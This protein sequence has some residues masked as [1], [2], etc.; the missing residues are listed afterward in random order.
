MVNVDLPWEP[1]Y[2]QS[3]GVAEVDSSSLFYYY[4]LASAIVFTLVVHTFE[5]Y[6]DARQ[7]SSYKETQFP[8]E[9]ETTVLAIDADRARENIINKDTNTNDK[10]PDA[11]GDETEENSA[12]GKDGKA[13]T[14]TDTHKP[15]LPQLKEKFKSAQTYGLDKINFGMIAATYGTHGVAL[16]CSLGCVNP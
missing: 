9:L 6:L 16:P 11:Q 15:L 8:E 7:R 12:E 5:A 14:T 10:A 1:L 2:M 13:T 4:G 3:G